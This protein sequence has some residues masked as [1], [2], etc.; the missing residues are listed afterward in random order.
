MY[1]FWYD[2][3]TPK[4]GEKIK[5]CYTDTESFIFQVR[6]ED[7]Y[8]DIVPDV[9]KWFDTS[10]Y[11]VDRP[12]PMGKNKKALCKFKDELGARIMTEYASIRAKTY[13]FLIHDFEET[14]KNKGTKKCV[15]KRILKF[16]DYKDCLFNKKIILKLQQRFKSEAHNVYTEV[17]KITLRSNDD[18][19]V[20]ASDGITS[21]PYGR[22]GKQSCYVNI[23]D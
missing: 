22:F 20:W 8:E 21:Y 7:F 16:N 9:D 19:G 17:D 14:K 23:N 1:E 13:S 5:L 4:Y 11:I 10:G 6:T 2:Y 12:L 3:A 18:K 15:V